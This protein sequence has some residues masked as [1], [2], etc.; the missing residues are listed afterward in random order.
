[1]RDPVVIDWRVPS[2]VWERFRKHVEDEFGSLDGY[3]GRE[4]ES[5]MREYADMDGGADFEEKFDQLIQASGRTPGDYSKEKTSDLSDAEDTTRVTARVDERVKDEFRAVAKKGDDTFGVAFARAIQTHLDGGRYGR[6]ERK[7]D[8]I[9]D[10]A[11]S[12]LEE[13]NPDEG[14]DGLSAVER[15]TITICNRLPD[16]FTDDELVQE[17]AD[18]AGS[19][20]PTIEKYRR[21]VVDRLDSEPHPHA[22]K[23]IWVPE[24]RA[25]E[26]ADDGTPRVCRQPVELLDREER[27]RRIQLVAGRRAAKQ[28]SGC[29]RIDTTAVREDVLDGDVS[30]SSVL[31]LMDE[32][33]LDPGFDVNK[34]A[35]SAS[36][37]VTLETVGDATPPLFESIIAYRDGDSDALIDGPT[38]S[39]MGD[40]GET[41]AGVAPDPVSGQLDTLT[42]A[43]TDGGSPNRH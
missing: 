36:L 35:D 15:R 5:A 16:Q 21:R 1:M 39:T 25:A 43:V 10:D 34:T 31:D 26:L 27:V 11:T 28:S 32:A 14:A 20:D 18:V 22:S 42:E 12:V 29:V 30:K 7:L 19:S 9:L 2:H 33:A 8:R 23:T 17:I 24:Q 38:E 37:H 4:A 6:L 40:F 3:L 41:D 13:M